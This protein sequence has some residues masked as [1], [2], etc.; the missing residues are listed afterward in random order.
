MKFRCSDCTILYL[1]NCLKSAFN[2]SLSQKVR[3]LRLSLKTKSQSHERGEPPSKRQ[4]FVPLSPVADSGVNLNAC[5]DEDI[6]RHIAE[7][8]KEWQKSPNSR[9]ASHVKTLLKATR[10]DRVTIL[11]DSAQGC[12]A[13]VFKKYPCFESCVHLSIAVECIRF[14]LFFNKV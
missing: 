1:C 11:A 4:C 9:S 7:L 5:S 2:K 6:N 8:Q 3:H 10:S 12:M 13:L 14:Q